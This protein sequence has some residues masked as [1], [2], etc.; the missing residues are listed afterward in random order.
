MSSFL[1]SDY[2][3]PEGQFR[4]LTSNSRNKQRPASASQ[5]LDAFGESCTENDNG[6]DVFNSKD[7]T[8]RRAS[9][10]TVVP[11][12]VTIR[13]RSNPRKSAT[14]GQNRLSNPLDQTHIEELI[15]MGLHV[16]QQ[17]LLIFSAIV[18]D[19]V[20]SLKKLYSTKRLVGLDRLGNTPLHIAAQSGNIAVL[21]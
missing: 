20:E 10:F 14:S 5:I 17:S 8:L 16:D 1:Y 13:R 3:L 6:E 2:C 15:N 18:N 9:T 4:F 11:M 7:S 19:D 21:K 12:D